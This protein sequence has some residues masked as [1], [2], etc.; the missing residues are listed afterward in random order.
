MDK[1]KEKREAR[2]RRHYRVRR[3]V[4]GTPERPRLVVYRSLEHIYAQVIDD[5]IGHTLASASTIDSEV[6]KLLA[7]KKKTEEAQVVGRVVAERAKSA[8]VQKV[9]FDRGGNQYHGRVKALAEAAR[10][11]GLEF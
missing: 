6:R 7:G 2:L 5:T 1:A 4:K 10:E 11:A 9:V 3:K 8:G